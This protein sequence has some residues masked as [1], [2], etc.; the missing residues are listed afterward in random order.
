MQDICH[1]ARE[2]GE[3]GISAREGARTG[4]ETGMGAE[5]KVGLRRQSGGGVCS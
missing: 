2:K 4:M 5:A 1:C 3:H